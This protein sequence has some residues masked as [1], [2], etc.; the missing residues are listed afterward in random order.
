MKPQGIDWSVFKELSWW[1]WLASVA[2]LAMHLFAGLPY[3]IPTAAALC[4]VMAG[5]YGLRLRGL[6]PGPVQIRLVYVA[7]LFIGMLPGAGWLYWSQLIGT[8]FRVTCGYC[9]LAR[10]L[11]L[12]PWNRI[13]APSAGDVL[14]T[15]IAPLDGALIRFSQTYANGLS[16]SVRL[17]TVTDSA[18]PAPRVARG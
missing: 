13:A 2:L 1:H 6:R 12:M 18:T 5:Y 3:A 11:S 7:M 8:T 10:L 16:C 15:L 4:L 9:L 17:M 14:R